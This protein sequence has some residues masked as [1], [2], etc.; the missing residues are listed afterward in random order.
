MRLAWFDAYQYRLPRARVSAPA[1]IVEIDEASLARH[2]QWPWPRTLLAK[3]VVRVA[4][5]G[6]A[7]I[8]IDILMPESD[9]LSPGALPDLV[10]GLDRDLVQ[11]LRDV[12]SNDAMFASAIRGRP[13]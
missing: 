8:G 7:A 2:G 4:A 13:V 5:A 12:P 10:P 1:V 9:R 11:R 3:L 6:P